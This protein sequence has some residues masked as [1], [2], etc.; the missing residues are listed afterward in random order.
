M[1]GAAQF[2]KG[3]GNPNGASYRWGYLFGENFD[4]CAWLNDDDVGAGKSEKGS[5]CGSPQE[6]DTPYFLRR[7]PSMVKSPA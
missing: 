3:P 4:H 7:E 1:Q 5:R 2:S 6:I